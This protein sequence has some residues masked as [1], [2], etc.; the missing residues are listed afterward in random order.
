M[1]DNTRLSCYILTHD[2]ERYLDQVLSALAPVVDDLLLVDSGSTD[3]TRQ[4]AREFGAR[5]LYR[6][7]DGFSSQRRRSLSTTLRRL[8]VSN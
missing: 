2:S 1:L 8:S 3:R 6:P 5:F 4:I 7:L